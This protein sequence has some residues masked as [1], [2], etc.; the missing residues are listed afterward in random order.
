MMAK[1]E[2][3]SRLQ[4][5]DRWALRKTRLIKFVQQEGIRGLVERGSQAGVGGTLG[6]VRRQARYQICSYLGSQ[7]DRRYSVDTAG[8]IDL[9]DIDVLGPNK[10]G[11]YASVSTS[12]RAFAFLSKFFP[13]DSK[14]FTFVDIG[15]G[16]GRV[17][18]L[19][20]LQGFDRIIGVEFAPLLGEMA[21]QN[22]GSFSGQ[23]PAEWSVVSADAVKLELPLDGPLL[24]YSFNP[25]NADV[26]RQFVPVLT[27]A[28]NVGKHPLRLILSGTLPESLRATAAVLQDSAGFQQ[29]AQGV[30]P[31]FLDAY[32]PYYY[33]I[34]DA[35]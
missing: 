22:L 10:A 33:W 1:D 34:F 13:A 16:K 18:L 9:E 27:R 17:L 4:A 3:S 2:L 11:G 30:T 7:W 12:P 23:R 32:A 5:V 29:R 28:R 8:Q 15:C 31:F 26:W 14:K 21:R 6:F 25:F 24:I 20:A 35:I 19:A